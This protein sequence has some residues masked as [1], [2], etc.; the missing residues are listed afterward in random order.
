MKLISEEVAEGEFL[1]KRLACL[2]ADRNKVVG[3]PKSL[4]GFFHSLHI[5]ENL[6]KLL[7]QPH[8]FKGRIEN[9]SKT[10]ENFI[11]GM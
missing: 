6:N 4:F 5:M 9:T 2:K 10:E 7:G 1:M 11:W 3:W 8:T